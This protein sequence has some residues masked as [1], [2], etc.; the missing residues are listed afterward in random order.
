MASA[1]CGAVSP[2]APPAA[3]MSLCEFT[4]SVCRHHE[5]P[6][7]LAA[8][9]VAC[10]AIGALPCRPPQMAL[11]AAALQDVVSFFVRVLLVC[12]AGT[13]RH[14]LTAIALLLGENHGRVSQ[15]R[16]GLSEY[17]RAH[18][19]VYVFV[20][21]TRA[22]P[23]V[24]GAC[25]PALAACSLCVRLCVSACFMCV[26]VCSASRVRVGGC[27][28]VPAFVRVCSVPIAWMG[29]I[30]VCVCVYV[31]ACACACAWCDRRVCMACRGIV[32]V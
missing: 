11:P 7:C 22:R 19:C 32:C 4:T 14:A 28:S 6:R 15:V 10:D 2:S 26:H 30:S 29:V 23:R 18:V 3:L 31:C 5:V 21:A 12:D 9:F 24:A 8:P 13:A 17:C 1:L 20:W 25:V 27:A 16:G